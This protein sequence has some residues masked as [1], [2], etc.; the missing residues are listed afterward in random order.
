MAENENT[1]TPEEMKEEEILKEEAP[2]E[3]EAVE[4]TTEETEEAAAGEQESEEKVPEEETEEEKGS[5]GFKGFFKKKGDKEKAALKE[6]VAALEDRVRRQMAEFDNY[7]KRTDK[8]KESMFSMGERSV[9]EKMLP[10]LDNFE[11]GLA[12]VPEEEKG[13]S[14]ADGMDKILKQ[15]VKQLEDLGVK[16]IEAVGKEFDPAYHNAVMQVESEEYEEGVVVQ[17]F[18]KG[19]MYKDT[20]LRHS[21]V[22]VAK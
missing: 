21:M 17:E 19:Y 10:I 15:F 4:E 11:R 3:E 8:E 2:A 1:K 20:V 6:Q 22:T 12:A 18:Q 16:P 9:I 14:F 5:E 13:G 7:R